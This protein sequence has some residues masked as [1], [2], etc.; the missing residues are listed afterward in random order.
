[1]D[2]PSG[3]QV[4]HISPA[5]CIQLLDTMGTDMRVVNAARV[6]FDKWIEES[7]DPS[8][9]DKRLISYLAE[10]GHVS[11]FFHPMVC[12]RIEMPIFVAR[13]WFRHKVG[14]ERNEVSRR[15]VETPVR[16]F[17]PEQ[18]RAR[19]PSKKQGSKEEPVEKHAEAR[20][21]MERSMSASI[22]AYRTL[23]QMG[24]APEVARMVL[25]QSMM[26]M[27]VETGSLAAYARIYKLRNAPDAQHEIRAYARE[28]GVLLEK[29][30]PLAWKA[31]TASE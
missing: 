10:H 4:I 1:M 17:L 5:D 12:L 15:Y 30:F 19:N 7:R 23:L 3:D 11:P 22:D 8:E 13:E 26:T 25:P 27:F 20:S 2:S 31:L 18:V 14:I 29:A 16:C 28:I 6:S 9:Q 24:T 21:V